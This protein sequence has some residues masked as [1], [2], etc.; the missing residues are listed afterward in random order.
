MKWR[1]TSFWPETVG[2]CLDISLFPTWNVVTF[3]QI[4]FTH[5]QSDTN[6]SMKGTWP[7]PFGLKRSEWS[8]VNS[9]S[10]SGAVIAFDCRSLSQLERLNCYC[11]GTQESKESRNSTTTKILIQWISPSPADRGEFQ[12]LGCYNTQG[13]WSKL[14]DKMSR[15]RQHELL[16]NSRN[17]GD[18]DLG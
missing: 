14:G 2:I 10:R 7:D 3:V 5:K 17:T 15:R 18:R 13:K 8:L 9:N 4:C 6:V 12:N 16:K 11:S 1:K